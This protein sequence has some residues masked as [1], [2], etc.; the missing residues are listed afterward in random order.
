MYPIHSGMFMMFTL[1]TSFDRRMASV[2]DDTPPPSGPPKATMVHGAIDYSCSVAYSQ[3]SPKAGYIRSVRPLP[4]P[5]KRCNAEA[6]V[7][8]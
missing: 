4:E 5:R 1:F 2:S 8:R 3:G 7:A 6:L